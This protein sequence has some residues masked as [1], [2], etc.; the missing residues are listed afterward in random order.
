MN[1][2]YNLKTDIYTELYDEFVI[3]SLV[4]QSGCACVVL[5]FHFRLVLLSS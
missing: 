5:F 4:V 2:L 1:I 3:N